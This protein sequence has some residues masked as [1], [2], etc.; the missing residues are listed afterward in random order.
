[1]KLHPAATKDE[2]IDI[3]LVEDDKFDSLVTQHYLRQGRLNYRLHVVRKGSEAFDFLNQHGRYKHAPPP[4]LVIVDI[5][6]PDMDG[7]QILEALNQDP[8][9][10]RISTVVLTGQALDGNP[11]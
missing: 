5:G 9:L 2:L 6:L 8:R 11:I 4:H 3:L 1:M 10:D 7:R